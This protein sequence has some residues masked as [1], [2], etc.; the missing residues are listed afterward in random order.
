MV[1]SNRATSGVEA[2]FEKS[3]FANQNLEV[4]VA[5][6]LSES[7]LPRM[8][9]NQLRLK[10]RFSFPSN[11][12]AVGVLAS[13]LFSGSSKVNTVYIPQYHDD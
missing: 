8:E 6:C 4:G 11:S 7:T 9:I 12:C 10:N 5:D 2:P 13:A 1:W 3:I